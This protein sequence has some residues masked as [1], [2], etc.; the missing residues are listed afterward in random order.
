M[1]TVGFAARAS[2]TLYRSVA[3]ALLAISGGGGVVVA[4]DSDGARGDPDLVLAKSLLSESSEA[5]DIDL[6]HSLLCRDG[7]EGPVQ[8][9]LM[10]ARSN[11]NVVGGLIR[12][13]SGDPDGS[14]LAFAWLVSMCADSVHG[15]PASRLVLRLGADAPRRLWRALELDSEY[16]QLD[17]VVVGVTALDIGVIEQARLLAPVALRWAARGRRPSGVIEKAIGRVGES[18]LAVSAFV[19]ELARYSDIRM[20]G[21]VAHAMADIGVVVSADLMR[22]W[23][24]SP[25]RRIVNFGLVV[26]SERAVRVTERESQDAADLAI[27]RVPVSDNLCLLS[28]IRFL[29]GLPSVTGRAQDFILHQLLHGSE[30]SRVES[31]KALS[32]LAPAVEGT[33]RILSRV[34][35]SDKSACVR[36]A[37]AGA[38]GLGRWQSRLVVSSL[39]S[40]LLDSSEYVRLASANSLLA[41][42]VRSIP[43]LRAIVLEYGEGVNTD[44]W[45]SLAVDYVKSDPLESLRQIFS[46]L[47][48]STRGDRVAGLRF[49]VG[50][51]LSPRKLGVE[52]PKE[53]LLDDDP[54]V[55]SLIQRIGS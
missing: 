7:A 10:V 14:D 55:V 6:V 3:L 32:R 46:T 45:N 30:G 51:A 27:S 36:Q 43:L 48:S 41:L 53:I 50:M 26:G 37:C 31:V 24:E 15:G 20:H 5:W 35:A 33:E 21:T 25:D 1:R 44:I 23:I 13:L 22:R 17:E 8:M 34:L 9:L 16:A 47:E 38:L 18:E 19:L 11:S 4:G 40:A 49:V 12:W 29:G 52:I 2:V 42:G 54:E 39:E 28:L